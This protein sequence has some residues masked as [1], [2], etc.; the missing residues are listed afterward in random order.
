MGLTVNL[1]F[2]R[3]PPKALLRASCERG[4]IVWGLRRAK[5][6]CRREGAQEMGSK[7]EGRV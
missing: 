7:V 4:D 1:Y 6:A 2:V 5:A 3:D